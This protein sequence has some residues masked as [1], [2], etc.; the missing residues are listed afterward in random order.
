[1]S[2]LFAHNL[3]VK[4]FI[5]PMNKTLPGTTTLGQSE[6]GIDGNEWVL[7][8][9]QISKTEALILKP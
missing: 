4:Q 7:H 9:P 6:P 1:M 3:N 2:H 8:I 5:W